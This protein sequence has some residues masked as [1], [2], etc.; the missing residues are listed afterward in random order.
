MMRNT[1]RI[2]VGVVVFALASLGAS[3]ASAAE[4]RAASAPATLSGTQ[5]IGHVLTTNAGKMTCKHITLTG[6]SMAAT[7]AT[8]LTFTPVYKECTAFGFIGVTVDVNKCTITLRAAKE[9]SI[10]CSVGE[11]IEITTPGCTTKL[12]DQLVPGTNVTYINNGGKT[13]FEAVT[14]STGVLYNECGTVRN[15]ATYSGG[16]TV[17]GSVNVWWQ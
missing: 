7:T 13:D 1:H 9:W 11:A 10:N 12:V 4:F 8:Q 14:T 2:V 3:A 15:N 5:A 16:T 6:G 17:T